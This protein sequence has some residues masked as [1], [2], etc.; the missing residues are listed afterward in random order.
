MKGITP[1]IAIILLLL[2]TISMVG[3]AFVWFSKMTQQTTSSISDQTNRQVQAA[4]ER[5]VIDSATNGNIYIRSIG[6]QQI[7]Q[8]DLQVYLNGGVQACPAGI[9]P[10]GIGT[11]V[12]CTVAALT[13]NG[14]ATV[15]VTTPGS[16]DQVT[17]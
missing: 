9:F 15:K 8:T 16:T 14:A 1:V 6:N 13:C 5:V 4:G 17:C 10:I 3:F 7:P 12:D 11:T 2:I